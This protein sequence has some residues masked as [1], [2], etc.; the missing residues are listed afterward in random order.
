VVWMNGKSSQTQSFKLIYE[1]MHAVASHPASTC[2]VLLPQVLGVMHGVQQL[3]VHFRILAPAP[4]AKQ[5]LP[6]GYLCP[7]QS[8]TR[9]HF[10]TVVDVIGVRVCRSDA[11]GV[12]RLWAQLRSCTPRLPAIRSEV[13]VCNSLARQ[14]DRFLCALT[15]AMCVC[16]CSLQALLS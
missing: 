1:I 14:P 16:A 7:V 8:R 3:L 2:A 4:G 9:R 13:P 6:L 15:A 10:S 11:A 5:R 12:L